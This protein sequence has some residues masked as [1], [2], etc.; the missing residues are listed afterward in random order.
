MR[1][2]LIWAILMNVKLY[3]PNKYEQI[4]AV[5]A[6]D[7]EQSKLS[8]LVWQ[9]M[10]II[11]CSKMNL[12]FIIARKYDNGNKF[13]NTKTI[14]NGGK[15]SYYWLQMSFHFLKFGKRES[16]ASDLLWVNEWLDWWCEHEEGPN[17]N[18]NHQ[19]HCE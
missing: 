13:L 17:R 5:K 6:I 7:S 18:S 12:Q 14:E 11:D 3:I 19:L 16:L 4:S 8:M 1:G 2:N 15:L 10:L 9:S